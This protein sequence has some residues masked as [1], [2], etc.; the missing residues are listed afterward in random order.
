MHAVRA[1]HPRQAQSLTLW[2]KQGK[3]GSVPA[4]RRASSDLG[5]VPSLTGDAIWATRVVKPQSRGRRGGSMR[6]SRGDAV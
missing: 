5:V 3:S 1:R 6:L 4:L 2:D